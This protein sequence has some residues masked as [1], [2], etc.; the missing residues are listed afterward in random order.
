VRLDRRGAGLD[1]R[2]DRRGARFN[3]RH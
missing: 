1:R 3:R 2:L